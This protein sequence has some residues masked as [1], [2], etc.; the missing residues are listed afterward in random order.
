MSRFRPSPALVVSTIALIVA[1]GGT[2]Y[3][4]F[5]VP[6]NSVG[7][8]EIKNG[9]VTT[10]K[11]AR[12]AVVSTALRAASADRATTAI[13]AMSAISATNATNATHAS[14]ADTAT[15]AGAPATLASG[16]T[17]TGVWHIGSQAAAPGDFAAGSITFAFPLASAPTAH[18]I[19]AGAASTAACPGSVSDP[20]AS[21][22]NFCLYE[23]VADNVSFLGVGDPTT[24]TGGAFS[25]FGGNVNL[26]ATAAGLFDGE[27]SW[28]VT[29]P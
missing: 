21:P 2:S 13:N 4:A 16:K 23:K 7:T 24:D 12:G 15:T 5:S 28:A 26:D 29:A 18:I 9:A 8:K 27:G 10:K 19:K 11:L 3:A 14:S 17:L 1:L 25:R 22:G 6:A 20:Q